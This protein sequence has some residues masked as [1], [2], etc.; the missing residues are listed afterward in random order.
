MRLSRLAGSAAAWCCPAGRRAPGLA[1]R[2]GYRVPARRAC[3]PANQ[4]IGVVA[5][6]GLTSCTV[7]GRCG[8]LWSAPRRPA[9]AEDGTARWPGGG[10]SGR[11]QAAEFE[12]LEPERLELGEHAIQRGVVGQRPGQH[13]VAAAGPGLQGRE[14]GAYRLAQA[15][16]DTDAV[17]VGRPVGAGTGHVLTTHAVN[18]PAVGSTVIRT[19]TGD[20][21]CLSGSS[22]RATAR[23]VSGRRTIEVISGTISA[24]GWQT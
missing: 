11:W 7:P 17:P 8:G 12:Q 20:P 24:P 5:A 1:A 18:R 9:L 10:V 2:G 21:S 23:P 3:G 13:G 22:P 19:C 6:V 4:P 14:R 15:A 16:A